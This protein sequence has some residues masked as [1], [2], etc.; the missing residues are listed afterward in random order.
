MEKKMKKLKESKRCKSLNF[1][2]IELLI[3]IAIIAIL[4]AM[5]LP[6]LNKARDKAKAISCLSNLKQVG[7]GMGMYMNDFDSHTPYIHNATEGTWAMALAKHGYL[8]A[9][10][11]GSV[12]YCPGMPIKPTNNNWDTYKHQYT[13]GIWRMGDYCP[14]EMKN[15]VK[16]STV[17]GYS[18]NRTIPSMDNLGTKYFIPS[19]FPLAMDSIQGSSGNPSWYVARTYDGIGEGPT[20]RQLY[21]LHSR[22]A[23]MVFGDGHAAALSE[24]ELNDSGWLL[25]T[26]NVKR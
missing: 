8:P 10:T 22:K 24:G 13:Y 3:V 1:T 21:L 7:L 19:N 20:G 18:G 5:L 26:Y 6:A 2:L 14:W 16:H 9:L 11:R 4:A 15:R 23:N 25:S 12:L 17:S